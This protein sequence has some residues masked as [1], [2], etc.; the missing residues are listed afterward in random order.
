MPGLIAT[1]FLP[2]LLGIVWLRAR[3]LQPDKIAWPAILGYGYLAGAL[4]TTLVMRLLDMLGVRLGFF[5]IALALALL[6]ALGFLASR[7]VAWRKSGDGSQ[8]AGWRKFAFIALL[9]LI[10][11]RLIGLGLEVLWQ[12]LFP[13]DAW[14][15]W[16]TKAR[17]WYET[18]S[19]ASFVPPDIWLQTNG[20]FTDRAPH[21]PPAIPLLQAWTAFGL[22]RWD[23]ALMNLPWLMTGIALALAFYGQARQWGIAPLFAMMFTYFLLSLPMLDTHVALAGYADLFLAATYGLAA[24]AFFH[25]VRSRDVWQGAMALVL[26]AGC[27]LIKQPGI[28]WA[29]TFVPALW[30]ALAPRHGLIG[31]AVSGSIGLAVALFFGLNGFNLLGYSLKFTYTSVWEPLW[32]NLMVQDN[33]HLLFYLAAAALLLSLPRLFAPT[34]RAMTVVVVFALAFVFAIFFFTHV[35]MWVSD[36]TVV[37]R[38]IL[39]LAPMLLFYVMVLF[40]E[41]PPSRLNNVSNSSGGSK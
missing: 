23:D 19:M 28:G 16:A 22:G 30:V 33:W 5:S 18:G 34:Y 20:A 10:A 2:W 7:G 14:S 11:T 1:V 35:S 29:L 15:Q 6:I 4:A 27:I 25:W 26:G 13:W 3:W 40:W 12:P 17:V 31:L 21:Y 36:Q 37:N 8:L 24:F 32:S 39:H 41:A 38:A 9:V